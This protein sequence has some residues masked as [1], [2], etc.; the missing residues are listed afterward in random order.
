MALAA[1]A[2]WRP[3]PLR[4]PPGAAPAAT[5]TRRVRCGTYLVDSTRN[6]SSA[7][8]ADTVDPDPSAGR[9]ISRSDGAQ[10]DLSQRPKMA[11]A[12]IGIAKMQCR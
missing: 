3:P 4:P 5:E 6:G 10:A 9:Y 11:C 12:A 2:A 7:A 8:T 1:A